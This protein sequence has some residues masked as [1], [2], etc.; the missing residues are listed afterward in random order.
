[1]S[2]EW[3]EIHTKWLLELPCQYEKND[4]MHAFNVVE[5]KYGK[6][7][8]QLYNSF[9]GQYF[10]KL[11]FDLSTILNKE[12]KGKTILP[13]DG[14][15]NNTI[16]RNEVRKSFNLIGLMAHFIRNNLQVESEPIIVI[17][18]I[19]KKPDLKV[20][21]DELEIYFEETKYEIS[22]RQKELDLILKEISKMLGEI[23]RSIK[24]KVIT[25]TDIDVSNVN[26]IKEIVRNQCLIIQQPQL[27]EIPNFV[28]V[29][30][31]EEDQEKPL[32]ADVRPAHAM[33]TAII[34]SGFVRNLT[35]LIPFSYSRISNILAKKNQLSSEK[36]NV[37]VVDIST[38]GDL[39]RMS[40]VL[41]DVISQEA[42]NSI[43]AILL[44]QKRYFLREM[45]TDYKFLINQNAKNSIPPQMIKL[46]K[47][48]FDDSP[49]LMIR[50]I[51]R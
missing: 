3:N 9:R 42:H 5:K 20:N 48:Y 1:M 33:T 12:E 34:G 16:E 21:Y 36:C 50:Q 35:V 51:K 28:T 32:I 10:A 49:S 2:I 8:F 29:L 43:G 18:K 30:T 45:K 11:V 4:L 6:D 40:E 24:I 19:E 26:R 31:Y 14:E 41:E 27:L 22:D 17:N 39:K 47:K 37:I 15:I 23:Q 7:F 44:I 38:S 46:I 25:L 13:R